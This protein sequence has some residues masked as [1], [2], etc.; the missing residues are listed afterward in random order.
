MTQ[1]F[2]KLAYQIMLWANQLM[3]FSLVLYQ[4]V[5]RAQLKT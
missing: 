1:S 2:V 3:S 5:I 4:V